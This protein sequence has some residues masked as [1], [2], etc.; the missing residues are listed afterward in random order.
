[1]SHNGDFYKLKQA[2]CQQRHYHKIKAQVFLL[3]G[4]RC[5]VCGFDDPRALQ[6]DHIAGNGHIERLKLKSRGIYEKILK[7]FNPQ[8]EYQLLCANH[9]WI[10]RAENHEVRWTWLYHS[11]SLKGKQ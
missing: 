5:K 2:P 10:K 4:G 8:D 1:L 9:N 11:N 3:L 7:M 6:I